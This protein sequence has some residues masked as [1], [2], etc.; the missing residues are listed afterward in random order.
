[1]TTIHSL[2]ARAVFA[3]IK[4]PLQTSTGS[5]SKAPMVLLD[6]TT[7]EGVVGR[8]CTQGTSGSH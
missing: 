4:R 1:M 6:L 2:T 8:T 7:S 3:P 5:V